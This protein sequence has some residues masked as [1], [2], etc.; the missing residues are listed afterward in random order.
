MPSILTQSSIAA[1]PIFH[2]CVFFYFS[3][4]TI[5]EKRNSNA[6]IPNTIVVL[7][8]YAKQLGSQY[9]LELKDGVTSRSCALSELIL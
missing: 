3:T 2:I 9:A 6:F 5:I 8:T 1:L 4:T 7:V